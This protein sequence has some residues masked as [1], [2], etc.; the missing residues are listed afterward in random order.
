MGEGKGQGTG[1][2]QENK[3]EGG[4][5]WEGSHLNK[6]NESFDVYT[7]GKHSIQKR[8]KV[9]VGGCPTS[10]E[11]RKGIKKMAKLPLSKG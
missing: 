8:S 1:M 7:L 3:E 4:G 11:D 5:G 10:G 6:G 9:L 2:C